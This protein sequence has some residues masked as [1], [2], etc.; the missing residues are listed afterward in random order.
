MSD[1]TIFSKRFM[2]LFF[3]Q[4]L[5]AFNDNF[6]K[7]FLVF[8]VLATV[9]HE[10][11]AVYITAAGAIFM[12]PFVLLSGLG[13]EMADKFD[14]AA[15]ARNLKLLEIGA[16]GVASAGFAMHS[17]PIM[18]AS[19]FLFGVGSA[20]F[21]P[22]KYGILPDHL[23]LDKLPKANAWIEAAT[24]VS[25]LAGTVFAGLTYKIAQTAA[26]P[27]ATLVVVF[28]IA[29]YACSRMIPSTKAADPAL[30]IDANIFR[31]TVRY[32]REIAADS[33][34][35]RASLMASFFWF[36]GAIT[37]AILP[38]TV[39]ALGGEETAVTIYMAVFAVSIALGSAVAAWLCGGRIIMLPAVF[40]TFMV[41]VFTLDFGYAVSIAPEA[42]KT[43]AV[44]DF[45]SMATPLRLAF[46]VSMMAFFGSFVAVPTFAAIQA[47]AGSERRARIVAAN[48]ILNALFIVAGAALI[49]GL[50]A[51]GAPITVVALVLGG[52][53][54]AASI[55]MFVFL[56]TKVLRDFLFVLFRVLYRLEV[57]GSENLDAAG[58]NPVIAL[59][60]VSF[61]DAALAM[62]VTDLNP[63]FAINT[64]IA[65]KWWVKPFLG[66][67]NA[68]PLDPS[69]PM[70]TRSLIRIVES[71]RPIGIFPEGRLTVTGTLMKVYDGAA[72]VADKTGVPIVA[73][74]IDGLER[75]HFS[76]L[77]P[78]QISRRFFPKVTVTILPPAPLSVDPELKGRRRRQEAGSALYDVMSDLVFRTSEKTGTIIDEVIRAADAYGHKKVILLD[79]LS[80]E[81]T[82]GKLLTAVRVLGGKFTKLF[83]K[84]NL[85]GVMLPN[86]VGSAAVFLGVISAGKVPS[87]INFTAGS[88]GV[89]AACRASQTK[90]VLT[91]R[92]FVEKAK[93]ES[94]VAD[95]SEIVEIVYTEDVRSSVT[96]V[97][98]L[99]GLLLKRRPIVRRKVDD[100]AVI[101]YTSGSEG[102]P[103]GVV[104]SHANVMS[105]ATQAAA[106]VDFTTQDRVFNVLPLFHAFG[107]TGGLLLPIVS[108]VSVY[109]YPSPLH[110][111][112]VPE[113][114]YGSNATI[115]FGTDTFLTG[116]AKTA[117]AY[118]FRSIRYIFAGAEKVYEST[119]NVYMSKFGIRILEGYGVT[120]AAPIISINTPMFNKPGS[121]G[122]FMPGIEYR[123]EPFDGVPDGGQLFIR[124]PNIMKGY[125]K[126]SE[127]GVLQPPEDGW[128]D[129]ADVVV[130]DS[131]GFVTIVDRA[132][133]F[134]NIAG[135][136]VS[137][138][139]VQSLVNSVW[140]G[141]ISVAVNLPCPKKGERIVILT[142]KGDAS[143]QEIKE[144]AK[145]Q[146]LQELVVPST[147]VVGK[148]PLLGSGKVDFQSSKKVAAAA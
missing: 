21:G 67:V 18:M 111:R 91:S 81:M 16:A 96:T 52:L 112:I 10:A 77:K 57:K 124:G 60:H 125:L 12:L 26:A 110:Y 69:K 106:R 86:S 37:L 34:L 48:N 35:L 2:P 82:Y 61:L 22:L 88:K 117:N 42:V 20:L 9:G 92:A 100:M 147:V 101:L 89:L 32:V 27:F 136:K 30:K 39:Q 83:A 43:L 133:R 41:G 146:G 25:I 24:F 119:R 66:I 59:N 71:G 17:L 80:G 140:P 115:L 33:R 4:A 103:K 7:N 131:E 40:G 95:M 23:P 142:E 1:S 130:I 44:L 3:T 109:L 121:V 114:I 139:G 73:I 105:N 122:R 75:T 94:L 87:M 144:A 53:C 28:A 116:Y 102:L 127:P 54:V 56:P 141:S 145:A 14:K 13:G 137:L 128:H 93:L 68:L 19:L 15:V 90:V 8:F 31:S 134:A 58:H 50:Q 62:A 143:L 148:V 108:G 70:A 118:D 85:V 129:T 97:D 49:G 36:A 104:L 123:L 38:P 98:K 113:L 107:L 63:V 46:D 132:G 6:L 74:R 78:D 135:E 64:D 11:G 47:W 126:E 76:R 51:A 79:P 45:F 120:E 55:A 138:A 65:K 29:C 84:E 72:M 5:A 99:V